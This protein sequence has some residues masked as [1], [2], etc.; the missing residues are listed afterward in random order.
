MSRREPRSPLN[1]NKLYRETMSWLIRP[2]SPFSGGR[3]S[4]LHE[5]LH[6]K[7]KCGIENG[8]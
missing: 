2:H 5:N 8:A 7:E 1:Q 4:S 3:P 6:E